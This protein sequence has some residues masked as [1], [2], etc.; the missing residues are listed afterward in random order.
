MGFFATG[1]DT[2]F[3]KAT[4]RDPMEHKVDEALKVDNTILACM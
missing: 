4:S 2:D 1:A 3:A